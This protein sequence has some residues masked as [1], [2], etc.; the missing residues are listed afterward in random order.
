MTS[1]GRLLSTPSRGLCSSGSD[2]CASAVIVLAGNRSASFERIVAKNAW[3][4]SPVGPNPN[5]RAPRRVFY[6]P[7]PAFWVINSNASWKMLLSIRE[8]PGS[9]PS[10]G[11][12]A[13]WLGKAFPI[14]TLVLSGHQDFPVT[15]RIS[16]TRPKVEP[17]IRKGH[18]MTATLSLIMLEHA[19]RKR[20]GRRAKGRW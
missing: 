20:Q 6:P 12:R 2:H 3:S 4:T 7:S 5:S 17:A 11:T 13:G 1:S 8:K 18:P 9:L 10:L 14:R 19:Y 15:G 16:S